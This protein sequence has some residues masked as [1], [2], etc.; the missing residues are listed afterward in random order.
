MSFR[1]KKYSYD[2]LDDA[3]SQPD[4]E[5]EMNHYIDISSIFEPEEPTSN[6]DIIESND[7]EVKPEI[8]EEDAPIEKR[9]TLFQIFVRWCNCTKLRTEKLKNI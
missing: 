5:N 8:E 9:Q 4:K 6:K 1:L 7:I 2:E 3:D